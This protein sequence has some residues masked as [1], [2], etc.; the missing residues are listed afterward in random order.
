MGDWAAVG[1]WVTA[2]RQ[3]RRVF[4]SEADFQH[5]LGAVIAASDPGVRVRLETRPV[6]GMRLDL[7]VS[8][9]DPGRN[10]AVELK[11]LTAA[12]T[13]EDGGER[14]ELL[15]QGAQDVRGYDV[16]K[17]VQRL[18]RLVDARPAWSGL[19]LVLA[20]DPAYWSRPAHGRATNG[21]AFRIYDGQ[22]LSGRRSWGPLT[23]AGTMKDRA[24]PI[25]LSGSYQCRWSDYSRL[26]GPRGTFRLL[27]LAVN[28]RKAAAQAVAAGRRPG[29]LQAPVQS[30]PE[31][32]GQ[33]HLEVA[34]PGGVRP[35][36]TGSQPPASSG[37]SYSTPELRRELRRFEREL[38]EAGLADNS[39]KTYVDRTTR[40]LRWL[41][42]DYH[43][44]R[45]NLGCQRCI[46][47]TAP[48]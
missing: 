7:L 34:P 13:G 48:P 27:T 28:A 15:G 18:E 37:Q 12:W 3:S 26:S 46:A 36:V 20:N 9:P 17:D 29:H 8:R 31:Q 24:S 43:P 47:L 22:V 25:E 19:V 23:G 42:G 4:H 14:F 32:E 1:S 33:L 21:D 11:Y 2:L 30:E 44:R 10:L 35:D 39:V 38:R 40:F 5:A 41:E 6:P 16:I 45:P